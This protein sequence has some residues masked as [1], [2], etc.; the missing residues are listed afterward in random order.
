MISASLE[1]SVVSS[2]DR[3]WRGAKGSLPHV[4]T[5]MKEYLNVLDERIEYLTMSSYFKLQDEV[6]G[7]ITA[8]YLEPMYAGISSEILFSPINKNYAFG[9]EI[10][11]VKAREFKQ[12]FGFREINGL[13]KV[14]GH[15]SGYLDT[16]FYYYKSQLD[17]GK[18]LAGDIGA[19][20]NLSRNFPNGWKVGGFFT[21]TDASF[22]E[23]G[24]GSFDK[25]IFMTI[26]FNSILPYQTTGSVSETI[27]P[28]QGDGGAKVV[29]NDRLYQLVNDKSKKSLKTNWGRI[30]R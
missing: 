22:Q 9:A 29:V 5:N 7:R 19:T 4:R 25:G 3:I 2:F 10:N 8:G 26:P 15:L 1:K 18:Y 11:T 14:N 13:S 27:K 23:F 28:I 17:V 20:F 21:L 24:E 30:W 16:G 12:L 6:Y